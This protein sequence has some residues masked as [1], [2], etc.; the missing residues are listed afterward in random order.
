MPLFKNSDEGDY[1]LKADL[2]AYQPKGNYALQQALVDAIATLQAAINNKQ[3]LGNYA[4]NALRGFQYYQATIPGNPQ[5]GE[6][7]GELNAQGILI[8]EWVYNGT[9]WIGTNSLT[10]ASPQVNISTYPTSVFFGYL[11]TKYDLLIETISLNYNQASGFVAGNTYCSARFQLTGIQLDQTNTSVPGNY[12]EI[13][14]II[15]ASSTGS[16]S[17]DVNK[18]LATDATHYAIGVAVSKVGTG[19]TSI[20]YSNFGLQYRLVRKIS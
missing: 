10:V 1:A 17:L 6:R 7:W 2:G 3:P 12:R 5:L 4:P 16:T 18:I 20:F 9:R 13:G 15:Q 14:I 8:D 19:S 11:G